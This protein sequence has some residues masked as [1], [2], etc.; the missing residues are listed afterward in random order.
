MNY[1]PQFDG[2]M[3]R[4]WTGNDWYE[5]SVNHAKSPTEALSTFHHL[6]DKRWFSDDDAILF[7]DTFFRRHPE[8]APPD[9]DFG[10]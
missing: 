1:E 8:L 4:F 3:F 2:Q 6:R 9:F 10:S 5:I 7:L